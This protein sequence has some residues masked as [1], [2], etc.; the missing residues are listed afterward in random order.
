MN[1]EPA[2]TTTERSRVETFSD[3]VLAIALTLLVLDLHSDAPRG[4]F[5]HELAHQW[6]G[7]VAYLAAFLNIAAIWT[8][9]HELFTRVRRVDNRALA[10]NLL[11]LLMASLLPW[12]AAVL[13]AAVREGDHHDQVLATTVYAGVGPLVPLAFAALYS[14]LAHVPG[15]L[16]GPGDVTYCRRMARRGLASATLFPVAAGAGLLAPIAALVIFVAVPALFLGALLLPERL[17]APRAGST[18]VQTGQG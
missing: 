1:D 7:Y 10:I 12:P 16:G 13:G 2:S 15:L 17:H 5:G 8:N 14:Y 9:H 11:V 18:T 4:E 6:P 3:G